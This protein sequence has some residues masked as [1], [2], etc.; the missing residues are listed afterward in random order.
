MCTTNPQICAKLSHAWMLPAAGRGRGWSSQKG[1]SPHPRHTHT[2]QAGV[3]CKL[4]T[5]LSTQNTEVNKHRKSGRIISMTT[6]T[7]LLTVTQPQH[8]PG[9]Q[10]R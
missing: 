1:H 3:R 7:V 9:C 5:E 8:K 2:S 10:A 4:L 6:D